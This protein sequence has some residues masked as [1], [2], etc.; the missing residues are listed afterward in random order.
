MT[1]RTKRLKLAAKRT[2]RE[3]RKKKRRINRGKI[4]AK[5]KKPIEEEANDGSQ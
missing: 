3:L 1:A 2:R 4:G 5:P